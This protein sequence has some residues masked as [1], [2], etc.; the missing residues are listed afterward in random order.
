MRG[1]AREQKIFWNA[2]QTGF[3]FKVDNKVVI[4]LLHKLLEM[5][6]SANIIKKHMQSQKGAAAYIDLSNLYDGEGEVTKR[7]I[8]AQSKLKQAKYVRETSKHFITL[9][10]ELTGHFSTHDKASMGVSKR[11]QVNLLCDDILTDVNS[12]IKI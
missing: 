12:K 2:P 8:S 9:I 6:A 7:A 11:E 3:G 5:S 4:Q 10:S 1:L